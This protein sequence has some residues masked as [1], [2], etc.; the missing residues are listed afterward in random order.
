MEVKNFHIFLK[1]R[2]LTKKNIKSVIFIFQTYIEKQKH[3][4]PLLLP[5]QCSEK[6]IVCFEHILILPFTVTVTLTVLET[7]S[8]C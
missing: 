6:V 4:I 8:T 1:L 3:T 2:E 7:L 5:V